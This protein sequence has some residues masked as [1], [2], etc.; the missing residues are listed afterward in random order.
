MAQNFVGSNNVPMLL[1]L[2]QFGTRLQGGKD[3]ASPRYVYT[4]LSP[5]A[6]LLLPRADDALLERVTDDGELVEPRTF[7]PVAP[8]V[9][10]NG[11]EGIGTGWST[12]VP[13]FH[14]VAVIDA[15]LD[16]LRGGR[17]LDPSTPWMLRPWYRGFHGPMEVDW[18]DNGARTLV[19]QGR[20]KHL[21][22]IEAKIM[23]LLPRGASTDG[24]SQWVK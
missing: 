5:M 10:M 1:P 21:S 19:S 9:L 23:G 20:A 4:R 7:V 24:M 8:L 3:A 16:R 17:L 18:S 2:G 12:Q 13:Q 22:A 15:V 14:P 11:A 6:R